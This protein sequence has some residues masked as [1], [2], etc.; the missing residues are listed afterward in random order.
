MTKRQYNALI[1][2]LYVNY[3]AYMER[4]EFNEES[5]KSTKERVVQIVV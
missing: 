3:L 1:K 4:G 2:E 5:E